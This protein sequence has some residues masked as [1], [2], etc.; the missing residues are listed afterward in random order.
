MLYTTENTCKMPLYGKHLSEICWWKSCFWEVNPKN[1]SLREAESQKMVRTSLKLAGYLRYLYQ[2]LQLYWPT[3]L[4]TIPPRRFWYDDSSFAQHPEVQRR[5]P[6]SS[7]QHQVKGV[8]ELVLRRHN[9][10]LWDVCHEWGA[11][12][13]SNYWLRPSAGRK[14]GVG[15]Y[16][17]AV[18]ASH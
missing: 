1:F 11:P 3:S 4:R 9:V 17:T 13:H 2:G 15:R 16:P 14:K 18:T 8:G 7:L 10:L 12:I 6:W 5:H